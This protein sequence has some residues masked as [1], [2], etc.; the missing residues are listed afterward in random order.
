MSTIQEKDEGYQSFLV[1]LQSPQRVARSRCCICTLGSDMRGLALEDFTKSTPPGWAPHMSNYPLKLYKEKLHL[2]V[3]MTD[4]DKAKQGP[5]GSKGKS[6][7]RGRGK[8]KG[9]H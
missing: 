4:V 9:K 6:K 2:W 3:N 7:G 1:E 8:G 5:T